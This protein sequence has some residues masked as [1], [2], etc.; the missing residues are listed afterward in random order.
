MIALCTAR[1]WC[2]PAGTAEDLAVALDHEHLDLRAAEDRLR[3][4]SVPE[5]AAAGEHHRRAGRLDR[6]RPPRRR[7]SSRRA[8]SSAV[9]PASSAICGPSANG[10]NASLASAAPA[11]V[12]AVLARLLDRDPHRVDA[13]HLA[14]ADP[15]RL[16][17]LR[18][19]DRVR[20]DV[21]ADAPGEEQVA[22]LRLVELAGR[23]PPSPSRSSTSASRSWTSSPPSTR[24]KSRSPGVSA[25][26]SRSTRMRSAFFAPQRLDRRV[27]VAGREQHLDEMPGDSRAELGV[28]RPVQDR[29]A[30]ERRHRVGGER[31]L[32]R[33]LD[34]RRRPRRRTGSR[35]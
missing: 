4:A 30:A 24:L 35:A 20:R 18:E 23:R 10:K 6:C 33:L 1:G 7:A 29:D 15:D 31:A 27:V 17:V 26:R 12:V 13:A 9:T 14:G 32:P 16:Q 3:R 5:V 11:E 2:A 28:D 21:L 34:R 25:R 22:P 8:G 19:H